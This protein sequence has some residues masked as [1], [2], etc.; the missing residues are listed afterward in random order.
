MIEGTVSKLLNQILRVTRSNRIIWKKTGPEVYEANIGKLML[1]ICFEYPQVGGGQASGADI[2][3]VTVGNAQLT[4]FNGTD[5]ME[6]VRAVLCEAFPEW[7]AHQAKIRQ[8]LQTALA[9]LQQ[10]RPKTKRSR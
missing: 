3:Q 4:F 9:H 10:R 6:W 5:G 7:R 8:H 2:A 1:R